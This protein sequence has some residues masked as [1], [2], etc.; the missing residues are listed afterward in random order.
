MTTDLDLEFPVDPNFI[1]EPPRV[2]AEVIWRLMVETNAA[3]P[4]PHNDP[5]RI[6]CDVEFI[7]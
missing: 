5:R 2:G 3:R 1:S 6:K 4:Y 7:L